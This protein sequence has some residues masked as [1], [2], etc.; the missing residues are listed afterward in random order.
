MIHRKGWTIRLLADGTTEATSPTGK[1]VRSH[2]PPARA[3]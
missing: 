1:V 2:G 3:G